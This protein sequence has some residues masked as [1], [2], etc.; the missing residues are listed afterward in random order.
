MNEVLSL[1]IGIVLFFV[2]VLAVMGVAAEWKYRYA[3]PVKLAVC[4]AVSAI[5]TI[6]VYLLLER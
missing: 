5:V 6:T 1:V 2:L 4:G 3:V